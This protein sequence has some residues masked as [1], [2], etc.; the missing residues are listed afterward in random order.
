MYRSADL[1]SMHFI[2]ENSTDAYAW[3]CTWWLVLRTSIS[4]CH[5]LQNCNFWTPPWTIPYQTQ[6]VERSNLDN[7]PKNGQKF[8]KNWH[9]AKAKSLTKVSKMKGW[10]SVRKGEW[11]GIR[12]EILNAAASTDGLANGSSLKRPAAPRTC[13]QGR[14]RLGARGLG[15]PGG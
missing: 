14:W 9:C 15:E 13:M 10:K 12:H 1:F 2:T 8:S 7:Y 6:N 11:G 5:W 3:P 4:I